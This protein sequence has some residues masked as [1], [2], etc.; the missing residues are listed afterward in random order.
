MSLRAEWAT[1]A[2]RGE[3]SVPDFRGVRTREHPCVVSGASRP[4]DDHE[5]RCDGQPETRE[6][7]GRR[8]G[9]RPAL[10]Q[11]RR[12]AD[13]VPRAERG[14][15]LGPAPLAARG[16]RRLQD[17]QE[18]PGALRRPRSRPRDR[19]PAHRSDGHRLRRRRPGRRGQGA[20]RLR[21]HQPEPGGQGRRP[22]RQAAVGRRGQGPGRRRSP[23][24]AAGPPGRCH[25]G[26]DAAVRRAP[27]GRAP[28]LRLRPVRPHR[29][30]GRRP[31]APRRRAEAEP[32]RPSRRGRRRGR[33]AGRGRPT[34]DDR[35]RRP[36]APAADEPTHRGTAPRPPT[37]DGARRRRHP[38]EAAAEA[39]TEAEPEPAADAADTP[40]ED[41]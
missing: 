8:R 32:A 13:R 39:T 33:R 35:T 25:G 34:D 41:N 28:Q 23:R 40:T 14:R 19:G 21:P 15:H 1:P 17:L 9:P 7:R 3:L 16:R 4:P 26:A 6:G 30:E 24:G 2:R 10:R 37:T 12:P 36:T 18:H 38:A 22:R 31:R 5:R 11:R 27:A 20:A 29:A